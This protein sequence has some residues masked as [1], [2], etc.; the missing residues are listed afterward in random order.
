MND[1]DKYKNYIQ[2]NI[3]NPLERLMN[4]DNRQDISCGHTGGYVPKDSVYKS[5]LHTMMEPYYKLY[6]YGDTQLCRPNMESIRWQMKRAIDDDN[7]FGQ[8]ASEQDLLKSAECWGDNMKRIDETKRIQQYFHILEALLQS[9]C[10]QD[11]KE[12]STRLSGLLHK[13]AVYSDYKTDE[14]LCV[15]HAFTMIMQQAWTKE[16]KAENLDLLGKQWMFMK[17]YYSVMT[18]HIVG[19][20]YTSFVDVSKTVMKSSQS[21]LPHLHIYYCGLMDCA[22]ELDL[23]RKHRNQLDKVIL[24]MQDV[25]GRT[26]PSEMLYELCDTLFP[27]DFQRMMREHRPKTYQEMEDENRQKDELIRQMDEQKKHLQDELDRTKD[28]LQT[29]IM[30]AIPIDEVDAELMKYPPTMAWQL[31]CELNASPVLNSIQV[32]RN[33]YPSLLEKYRGLLADTMQQQQ[34]F[35]RDLKTVAE[36]PTNSYN[37]SNGAIHD[38][39]RSQFMLGEERANLLQQKQMAKVNE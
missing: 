15:L 9:D 2:N 23:D 32:W 11:W 1:T 6:L 27:E 22:D 12:M 20:K 10:Q 17:Y 16:K 19:V 24:K 25:I 4:D 29:M 35:A 37:Y 5:V 31:L 26:E 33:A 28:V 18:R 38:D 13:S 39:H 3:I 30:S 21:F 14:V 36:R 34:D 7:L 8:W